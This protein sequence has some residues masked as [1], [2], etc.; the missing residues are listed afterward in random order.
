[1]LMQS[2]LQGQFGC[3]E[4]ENSDIACDPQS[5]AQVDASLSFGNCLTSLKHDW[6]TLLLNNH[7]PSETVEYFFS[8]LLNVLVPV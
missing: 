5:P 7:H 1:M 8:F 2:S 6:E 4:T 3:F